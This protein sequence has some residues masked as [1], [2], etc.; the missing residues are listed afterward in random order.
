M[1][2]DAKFAWNV[3]LN[4]HEIWCKVCMKYDAKLSQIKIKDRDMIYTMIFYCVLSYQI[5]I[6]KILYM[7]LIN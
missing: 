6:L 4:L 3:M 5:I 7:P 2:C 1:K